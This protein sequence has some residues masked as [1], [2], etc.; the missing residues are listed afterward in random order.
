MRIVVIRRLN[1]REE[2]RRR[3]NVLFDQSFAYRILSDAYSSI[4]E[5][6]VGY[7]SE[8]KPRLSCIIRLDWR[9]A[10]IP[11][12]ENAL[13]NTLATPLPVFLREQN[14]FATYNSLLVKYVFKSSTLRG[15]DAWLGKSFI[16]L[17]SF[18]FS[19]CFCCCCCCCCRCFSSN[20]TL[21]ASGS[22]PLLCLNCLQVAASTL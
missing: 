21:H 1:G 9:G 11:K 22:P 4:S 10:T 12:R 14:E 6:K 15:F 2:R 20:K 7:K 17:F 5:N 16:F 3:I 13:K 18:S 8:Q 19:C